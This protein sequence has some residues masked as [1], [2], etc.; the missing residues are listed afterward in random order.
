[1]PRRLIHYIAVM[2]LMVMGCAPSIEPPTVPDPDVQ[3][4]VERGYFPSVT[5]ANEQIARV[6]AFERELSA[7]TPRRV[8]VPMPALPTASTRVTVLSRPTTQVPAHAARVIAAHYAVPSSRP[9]V[10]TDP[11]LPQTVR[12]TPPQVGLQYHDGTVIDD[13]ARAIHGTAG[14]AVIRLSFTPSAT[15]IP[16]GG[17][18]RGIAVHLQIGGALVGSVPPPP[19]G[20]WETPLIAQLYNVQRHGL[21]STSGRFAVL[22]THTQPVEFG[23]GIWREPTVSYYAYTFSPFSGF[24]A[25]HLETLVL[26]KA[27]PAPAG[28]PLPWIPGTG[29]AFAGSIALLDY[30]ANRGL[31]IS[32]RP[33]VVVTDNFSGIYYTQGGALQ[34][35]MLDSRMAG[36]TR[37]GEIVGYGPDGMYR[38]ITPPP[39]GLA[40]AGGIVGIYPGNHSIDAF[41]HGTDQVCWSVSWSNFADPAM[42]PNP[43]AMGM[44]CLS[45]ADLTSAI[46]PPVAKTGDPAF[47]GV[48]APSYR[49]LVPGTAGFGDLVDAFTGARWSSSPWAYWVRAPGDSGNV[50]CPNQTAVR[51]VN[52]LT[53]VT[54]LVKCDVE[55]HGWTNASNTAPLFTG[56]TDVDKVIDS[57]GQEYN[58]PNLN[59]LL[60]LGYT[61][62]YFN[63]RLPTILAPN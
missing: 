37:F 39:P 19:S 23:S 21:L 35:G 42:S 51:R 27:L 56:L 60:S 13:P 43:A 12:S 55:F 26:P 25:V 53:G 46:I 44:H 28:S 54:Q 45:R 9:A 59:Y 17:V 24:T 33:E 22:D 58:N 32:H 1:M 31:M 30:N 47:G 14:D 11:V 3:R 10:V 61:R 18:Y 8:Y 4:A 52:I 6:E 34:L 48:A 63:A 29:V 38:V 62:S 36:G 40:G 49:L 20:M 57:V 15:P 2:A 5:Q 16:G 50:G 41:V 7:Q